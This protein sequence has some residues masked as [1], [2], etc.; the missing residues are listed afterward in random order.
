MISFNGIL[1]A[2]QSLTTDE[3]ARLLAALWDEASPEDWVAPGSD[4]KEEVRRRGEAY[5]RGEIVGDS[6]EAVRKR[7]R[8]KAGLDD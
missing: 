1:I 6:W 3:R 2:A 7:A 4:W 5:D 8:K